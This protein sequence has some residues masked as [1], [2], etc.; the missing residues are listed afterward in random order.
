MFQSRDDGF[1]VD[2]TVD[3]MRE[4]NRQRA[5]QHYPEE[6]H[7]EAALKINGTTLKPALKASPFIIQ[8][9]FGQ[10]NYWGTGNHMVLQ[11]VDVINCVKVICP[12]YECV[13]LFDHSSGHAKKCSGGLDVKDMNVGWGGSSRMNMRATKIEAQDNYLGP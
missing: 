1:G 13:F 6:A 11:T 8:F 5:D 4:I 7:K 12:D 9:P 3:E 2:L 10:G